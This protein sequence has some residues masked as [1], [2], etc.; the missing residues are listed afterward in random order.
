MT[1]GRITIWGLRGSRQ[2]RWPSIRPTALNN[3][4]GTEEEDKRG[5]TCS[6]PRLLGLLPSR[7]AT[8]KSEG[9]LA[10]KSQPRD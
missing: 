6:E 5:C 7:A 8:E 1:L 10:G 9:L 3:Q 4:Y 2:H